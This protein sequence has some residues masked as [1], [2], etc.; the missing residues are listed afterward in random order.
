MQR[1]WQWN[2]IGNEPDPE[3]QPKGSQTVSPEQQRWE[4]ALAR[5]QHRVRALAHAG[6]SLAALLETD[7][8]LPGRDAIIAAALPLFDGWTLSDVECDFGGDFPPMLLLHFENRA[9]A[10]AAKLTFEEDCR[11]EPDQGP[12]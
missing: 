6:M 1:P 3:G 5:L 9:Q 10:R 4:G 11:P 2:L 12:G 7:S 8:D